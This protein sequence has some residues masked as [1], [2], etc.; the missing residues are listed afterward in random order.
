VSQASL[1]EQM[2]GSA[3]RSTAQRACLLILLAGCTL[4]AWWLLFGGGVEVVAALVRSH[5]AAGNVLR[6]AALAAAF[7]VYF[8]RVQFTTFVFLKRGMSWTEVFT[9][10]PW[11]MAICVTLSL[12]G[13]TN[14]GRFG[15]AAIAG[16]ALFVI[17]SWMNSYAEH[18]RNAWK[19]RPENRGRLYTQGLFRLTRHPNYLGDLISFSGLCLIS[20]RWF[21]VIIPV[22][23]LCGFVFANIPALDTHLAQHYGAQFDEY[24]R[25]TSRLIPFVY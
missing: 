15:A 14:A 24:A 6:R 16:A 12:A 2:Y 13:G 21:T 10:A 7:S 23:M 8:I 11:V 18:Q 1:S 17:G 20:G 3:A 25:R 9:I 19:K 4:L 5:W 22:L